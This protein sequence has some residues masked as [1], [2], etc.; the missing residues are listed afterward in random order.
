MRLREWADSDAAWYAESVRDPLI[1][2]FTSESSTLEAQQV[3][4]A[5]NRLR[6]S[7]TEAGFLICDAVSGAR[8]GN[9][10]LEHD[11]RSGEVS[12]WVAAEGRGRGAATRALAL[13]SAWSFRV[14][15]VD[16]LT[17]RIHQENAASLQVAVRAGYQRDPERDQSREIK[18]ASWPML[19]FKLTRPAL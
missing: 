6:S 17:L 18:G 14:T 19:A 3:I 7:D 2:R 8:L 12:Y 10:A 9:I 11:G 5:M 4:T 1:L 13:F 16:E 15:G